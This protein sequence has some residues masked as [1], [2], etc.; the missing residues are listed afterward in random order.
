MKK[1]AMFKMRN[2]SNAISSRLDTAE[3]KVSKCE[4]IAIEMI[5]NETKRQKNG[6]KKNKASLNCGTS[7]NLTYVWLRVSKGKEKDGGMT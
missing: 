7:C 3:E 4:D 6:R 1:E 5:K 2:I